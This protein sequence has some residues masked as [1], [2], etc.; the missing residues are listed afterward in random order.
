MNT[1]GFENFKNIVDQNVVL[2]RAYGYEMNPEYHPSV[3]MIAFAE[4][5]NDVFELNKYGFVPNTDITLTFDAIQ[6]ACDLAPYVGVYR[7]YPIEKTDIICEVPPFDSSV[8]SYIDPSTGNAVT[9]YASADIWPYALGL[10][11]AETFRCEACDGKMRCLLSG[12]ELGRETTVVCDPYEHVDFKVEF[13]R[14]DDLYYSL[15]Y[16]MRNEEY[17][18]TLLFL[19]YRVDRIGDIDPRYVLSGYVHGSVLFFDLD[20]LGKY[21]EKIRPDVGDIVALDFPDENNREKYEISECLDKQLTQDGVNPLLHKYIWKCKARR[22]INSHEDGAP[23]DNEA[24]KRLDERREYDAVVDERVAEAVSKYDRISEDDTVMEDAVYGGYE[25]PC[26]KYDKQEPP[27]VEHRKYD[28]VAGGRLAEIARFECGQRLLTD[29]YLLIYETKTGNVDGYTGEPET[30]AY[31]ISGN[32]HEPSVDA[33]VFESGM[34][35]LKADDNQVVFVNIEGLATVV[36]RSDKLPP[37]ELQINLN[38]LYDATV[39]FDNPVNR[40]GCDFY[41]FRETRTVLMSTPE[42]LFARFP[43]GETH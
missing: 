32:D 2:K 19:T 8:T 33:A 36:A 42:G 24:D 41:K 30:E 13:P 26:D 1:S 4:I 35:W 5:N 37:D 20:R 14:N 34:R 21:A 18:E 31:V 39:D 15:N 11:R 6:F 23:P 27:R 25:R 22:Y 17:L 10:G 16:R 7:E 9:G 28:A 3:D 29:G 38:S 12:Y 43:D 40:P